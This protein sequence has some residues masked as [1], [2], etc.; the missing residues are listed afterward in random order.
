MEKQ[1]RPV[2]DVEELRYKG[3]PENMMVAID[4]EQESM[5]KI[6]LIKADNQPL[7]SIVISCY[8]SEEFLPDALMSVVEQTYDNL[9]IILINNGSSGDTK[10]IFDEFSE[11]YS[12]LKWKYIELESNVGLFRAYYIGFNNASGDFIGTVDCDDAF[13]IDFV[14][15]MVTQAMLKEADVVSAICVDNYIDLH[16]YVHH[17]MDVMETSEF[18]WEGSEILLR[19]LKAHG[20]TMQW[21]TVWSKM[22]SRELFLRAKPFLEKMEYNIA[23]CADVLLSTVL[24]SQAQKWVNTHHAFYYYARHASGDS[25]NISG[26]IPKMNYILEST[27]R[28]FDY[29]EDF[30]VSIG[31]FDE[32]YDSFS[33]FKNVYSS[34]TFQTGKDSAISKT[35]RKK[36]IDYACK[37]WKVDEPTY[38]DEKDWFFSCRTSPFNNSF[39]EVLNIIRST[40]CSV[41]SFDVF[42]T[43]IERPFLRPWDTFEILSNTYNKNRNTHKYINFAHYR[44]I[45]DANALQKKKIT[46][47]LCGAVNLREIYD[48]LVVM[49]ILTSGEASE[50]MSLEVELEKRFCRARPQGKYLFDFAHRHGKKVICISDMYLSADVIRSI[51]DENGFAGIDAVFVSSEER[52]CKSDGRLF[53]K[54]ISRL[55]VQAN[56]ICHI[57]DNYETDILM[58]QSLGMEAVHIS[59]AR[60]MFMG[61]NSS[62][63]SGQSFPF[64]FGNESDAFGP[65]DYLGTRCLMGVAANKV[66]NNPFATFNNESD[67]DSNPNILGYYVLGTYVFTIAKWLLDNAREKGYETIHFLARD[68]FV[69]KQ[70]YDV[71]AEN[72][73]KPAPK[74]NYLHVSRQAMM[75]LL[76]NEP[77]DVFYLIRS[78]DILAYSPERF[79]KHIRSIIPDATYENRCAILKR[80]EILADVNFTSEVEWNKFL[81]VFLKEFY[82]KE[83]INAYREQMKPFFCNIIGPHDCTFD[84]G[85]SARTETLLSELTGNSVSIFYLHFN[86]EHAL[87]QAHKIGADLKA[88]HSDTARPWEWVVLEKLLCDTKG[89]CTGYEIQDGELIYKFGKPDCDEDT[90]TMID[91][92][93]TK[94]VELVSDF[95]KTFPEWEDFEYRFTEKPF[96]YYFYHAKQY[97]KGILQNCKVNDKNS[98]F[99]N[100]WKVVD[101]WYSSPFTG[102]PALEHQIDNRSFARKLADILLPHGTQRRVFAKKILPKGSL[103]WKFCKQIYYIFAPQYRPVVNTK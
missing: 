42:D 22:Y 23:C 65:M 83:C 8:N 18:C 48:E 20:G 85:H 43:L 60:D 96:L 64:I 36:Y 5:N 17:P 74:S 94:A 56:K 100:Q 40:D 81:Q 68:G 38:V 66:F 9:E 86:D 70:A 80:N 4:S 29:V 39:E 79:L 87:R 76:I 102:M 71:L 61:K 1:Y 54:A 59:S 97:D 24:L 88:F 95:V 45:A 82:N 31:R 69:I 93:H 91:F 99:S 46:N 15:Q 53:K 19:Y 57:G 63:Y 21:C 14:Y 98:A 35:E 52:V 12:N 103:R 67:F 26:N 84:V 32:L 7:V 92:I 34:V 55:N 10:K 6:P 11:L 16:Q 58:A 25:Q 78:M 41:I 47:P 44:I 77:E 28:A 51:L 89:G 49:G 30:L 13:S 2:P 72:S 33:H 73:K 75:P 101:H 90:M 62:F 37:L 27:Q 3:I 50:F